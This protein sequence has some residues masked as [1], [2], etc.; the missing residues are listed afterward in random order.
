MNISV[1]KLIKEL[2]KFKGGNIERIR[3]VDVNLA[4]DLDGIVSIDAD[5]AWSECDEE[6]KKDIQITIRGYK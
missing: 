1:N 4:I 2:E 5:T 3:I 6:Q